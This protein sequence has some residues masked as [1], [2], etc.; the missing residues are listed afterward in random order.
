MSKLWLNND[1]T[2]RLAMLQKSETDTSTKS[3][4]HSLTHNSKKWGLMGIGLR[5]LP[6]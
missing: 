4:P 1:L 2:D 5:M 6:M 3:F